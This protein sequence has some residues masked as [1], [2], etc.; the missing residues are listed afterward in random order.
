MA[1]AMGGDLAFHSE[2]DQETCFSFSLPEFQAHQSGQQKRH[3]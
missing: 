2:P 1:N 3:S